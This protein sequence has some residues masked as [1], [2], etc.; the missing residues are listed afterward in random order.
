TPRALANVTQDADRLTVRFDAD[1]L[2]VA[3]P[4]LPPQPPPSLVSGVRIVDPV[5]L[6]VDLGPRFAGY[7]S[8]SQ[9][10]DTAQ[11]LVLDVLGLAQTEPSQPPATPPGIQAAPGA[12]PAPGVQPPDMPLAFGQSASA[13][14]TIAVDAGHGGDDEGVRTADGVKEKDFTLAL[15]RRVKAIIEARLGLRVLLTRDDDRNVPIDERTA[16]A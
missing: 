7:R 8:T 3:S 11:R 12:Q 15:A 6:A 16:L 13:I 4:A 10:M 1:A 5:T 2:D 9:P 14:H